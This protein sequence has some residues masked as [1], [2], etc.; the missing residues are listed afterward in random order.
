M[1]N[2]MATFHAVWILLLHLGVLHDALD[3][4][5]VGEFVDGLVAILQEPPDSLSTDIIYLS[6]AKRSVG[7]HVQ[8]A[9]FKQSPR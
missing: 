2:I 1:Q 4:V 8:T 3:A 7:F 6:L 9:G 5:E